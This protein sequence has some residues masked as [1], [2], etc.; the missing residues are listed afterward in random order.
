MMLHRLFLSRHSIS[1]ILSQRMVFLR[2]L[3]L[4]SH[5]VTPFLDYLSLALIHF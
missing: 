4:K 5:L 3:N 1:P 2:H